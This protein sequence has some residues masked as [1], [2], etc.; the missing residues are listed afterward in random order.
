MLAST[1]QIEE[2]ILQSEEQRKQTKLQNTKSILSNLKMLIEQDIDILFMQ[3]TTSHSN[4]STFAK[5]LKVE[6]YNPNFIREP[7]HVIRTKLEPI[8]KTL[9]NPPK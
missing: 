1:K 4:L 6:I 8:E 5:S 7:I 3:P 9:S 2:E